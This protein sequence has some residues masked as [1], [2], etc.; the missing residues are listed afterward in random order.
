MVRTYGPAVGAK[1]QLAYAEESKW[2]YPRV[3]PTNF[4]EFTS[5]GI[6]SEFTSLVSA[7]LRK[8]RSVHKSTIGTEAA[9]GDIG[10]EFAPEGLG[11]LFKH[12]FGKVRTK[13]VDIACVLVYTGT[14]TNVTVSIDTNG[15]TSSGCAAV[16]DNDLATTFAGLATHDCQALITA[17]AATDVNWHCYA[18]WGDGTDTVSG[19]YFARSIGNKSSATSTLGNE[20]YGNSTGG[21]TRDVCDSSHTGL[22]ETCSAIPCPNNNYADHVVFFPIFYKWGIFDHIFDT[23]KIVPEVPKGMSLEVGRDIAAFDYYG[24][25]VNTITMN[26]TPGEFVTGTVNFMAKGATTVGNPV[27]DSGNTGWSYPVVTISYAGASTNT[28]QVSYNDTTDVFY[29]TDGGNNYYAFS[30]ERG[31]L[32]HDGYY[33]HVPV[34]GGFVAFLACCGEFNWVNKP[35]VNY[36]GATTDIENLGATTVSGTG[37][38]TFEMDSS[39]DIDACPCFR[40]DYKGQDQ[41]ASVAF[42]V[43]IDAAGTGFECSNDDSSWGPSTTVEEGVWYDMYDQDRVDTGFDVMFPYIPAGNFTVGDKWK[44]D[45]FKDEN[46]SASYS[47]LNNFL[48]ARGMVYLDNS[49]H[50]VMGLSFTLN[51]NLFGEKYELGDRQRRGLVEQQL[52]AEGSINVEFDNLDLYRRFVNGIAAELEF[53]FNSDEYIEADDGDLSD[54]QY[55]VSILFP[56]IKYTGTTHVAGGPEI[57]QTDFPFVALYDDEDDI[58]N[59]RMTLRN[60]MPYV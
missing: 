56:K 39:L 58:P 35:V 31:Y 42:Y 18:P 47:L 28:I 44:I 10:F 4:F 7:A 53:Q 57:I 23:H 59:C 16:G 21:T 9:G 41:G 24:S 60:H 34:I 52:A 26:A 27:A 49:R 36:A 45:S 1:A 20:D 5:E 54:L 2:G 22:L 48:C 32:T 8:D 11:A 6:V 55:T 46:P 38:A 3:P 33:Y 19:G 15:I 14:A 43:R 30:T 37:S 50:P 51:N 40:G 29:M 17:L 13:R 12:G 25:K